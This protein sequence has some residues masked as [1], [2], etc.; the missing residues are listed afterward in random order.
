MKGTLLA[1]ALTAVFGGLFGSADDIQVVSLTRE[2]RVWVS[3]THAKGMNAEVREA[4]RAGLATSITYDVELRRLVPMWFDQ[5]VA[6]ATVIA[7]AQYDTLTRLYQ[8]SRTVDG[9]TDASK[10][11]GDEEIVRGWLTSS[12]SERLPLFQT[13]GLEPNAEYYIKV[14]ARTRPRLNWFFFLPLDRGAATGYTYFTFI[15]S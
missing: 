15:P 10:V 12:G 3:F 11:T 8:L 6:T 14:R 2:G 5:T 13:A 9:R 1:L 7:T 4:L